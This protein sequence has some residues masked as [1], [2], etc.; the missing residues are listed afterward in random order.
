MK[1]TMFIVSALALSLM[2]SSVFA[3]PAEK[4][5]PTQEK[6]VV[7]NV[8]GLAV[9]VDNV[10]NIKYT[11][12]QNIKDQKAM[13]AYLK[14][15]TK[16]EKAK[17]ITS[18]GGMDLSGKDFALSV[19][20]EIAYTKSIEMTSDAHDKS[21]TQTMTMKQDVFNEG[22]NMLMNSK[23]ENGFIRTKIN[24]NTN[25]L[26]SIQKG[27]VKQGEPDLLKT[28]SVKIDKS[29]IVKPNQ[30]VK[31]DSPVY[32]REGKEYKDIYLIQ[33]SFEQTAVKG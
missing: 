24:L 7:Y 27:D 15:I 29:F 12:L 2:S 1:K 13:T 21:L 9:P 4:H 25:T 3:S 18:G 22:F 20:K 31:F 11:D 14:A 16:S 6:F 33:Q 30:V 32:E 17:L 8:Y 5:V 28:H 26:L 19:N 23:E 10:K